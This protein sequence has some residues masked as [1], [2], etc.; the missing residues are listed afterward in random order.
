MEHA[1]DLHRQHRLLPRPPAARL[2]FVYDQ[3]SGSGGLLPKLTYRFTSN[4][5]ATVGVNFFF[6]R[7]ETTDTPIAPL[8]VV[9][10]EVGHIGLPRVIENGLAR[11]AWRD[12]AYIRIRYTF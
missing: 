9:G 2:T 8:G 7:W 10:N 12:E 1:R 3:Q 4:F 5:S 11:R 6:G